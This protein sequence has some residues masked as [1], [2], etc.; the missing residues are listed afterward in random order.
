MIKNKKIVALVPLRGGSKSIPRKNIRIIAGKPL[1]YWSLVAAKNSKYIDEVWVSTEDQ[2]IKKIVLDLDLGIKVVDRP[3]EFAQ[4]NSSTESVMLHF[5]EKVPFDIIITIQATSPLTTSNDLDRA[6]EEFQ[7]KG[8]DTMVSG[9]LQKR[10][11]W[12]TDGKPL[13]YDPMKRV[14]RQQWEGILMEN[15]AFYI[16]KRKILENIKNRLGGKIGTFQMPEDTAIEIDEPSDWDKV[17]KLLKK[18]KNGAS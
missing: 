3:K 5:A 17:A 8:L 4:D 12:T 6:I 16:T 2:N 10:L 7:D 1:A 11:F 18:K 9:V 14:P 15:G 13:N